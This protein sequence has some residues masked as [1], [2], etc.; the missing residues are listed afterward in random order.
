MPVGTIQTLTCVDL[1]AEVALF[2]RRRPGIQVSVPDAPVDELYA[3]PRADELDL[4]YLSPDAAE[5][6]DGLVEF[7]SWREE[8]V[9]ITAPGH[10]LARAGRTLIRDL[11]HESFI[12]FRAGTGLEIAVRRLAAHCGLGRR[13]TCDVTEIG[14]RVALVRAG[15]G[16]AFA[17][18]RIGEEAGV[19]CVVPGGRAVRNRPPPVRRLPRRRPDDAV[20]LSA[21]P[22]VNEGSG[23]RAPEL[24]SGIEDVVLEEPA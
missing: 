15:I 7:A 24:R 23:P 2:H 21:E 11:A 12:D 1:P 18:R 3:G 14:V 6:P 10:R 13:I 20:G 22:P 9:L 19:P 16:I 17:L 8:P 4:A 5:L